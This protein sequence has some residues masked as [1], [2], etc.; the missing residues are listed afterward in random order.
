MKFLFEKTSHF[1]HIRKIDMLKLNARFL[2]TG[3]KFGFDCL[4]LSAILKSIFFF[5]KKLFTRSHV[6]IWYLVKKTLATVVMKEKRAEF[7]FWISNAFKLLTTI[8][9]QQ[10]TAKN[11]SNFCLNEQRG[12]TKIQNFLYRTSLQWITFISVN[13]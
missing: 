4:Y 3:I 11:V 13:K 12:L 10:A 7:T 5:I 8:L 1:E 6:L 2:Q 9:F